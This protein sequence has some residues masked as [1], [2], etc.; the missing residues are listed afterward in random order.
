V[1]AHSE[2]FRHQEGLMKLTEAQIHA[3]S[4]HKAPHPGMVWIEGGGF[5]MGSNHHYPEEAP[6][7][8]TSVMD[9]WIDRAPV[10]N[11]EFARFVA[12]TGHVTAA[13]RATPETPV[14]ASMVFRKP[15]NPDARSNPLHWW[16]LVPGADWNHPE[17]PASSI[18]GRL[19]HPAVHIA[20]DDAL[21]YAVWAGK[22]LP[23][24]SEW[25]YAAR[26]GLDGADYSW[27]DS[28]CPEGRWMANIWRGVFPHEDRNE[29]QYGTTRV[30]A[31]PPNAYGLF[32]MIGNV[33]EWTTDWY[34]NHRRPDTPEQC[35]EA[36]ARKVMKGGSYLSAP[37]DCRRYR[38]A[39]RM[40]QSVDS[41][42]CHLGFRC[43]ARRT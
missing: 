29:R 10:T 41:G 4:R 7:H 38:P 32:D 12:A 36:I 27:G 15:G 39:A 22:S 19:D 9:F 1:K 42:A 2:I 20:F 11:F 28:F 13:E 16:A 43:V 6:A 40:A 34:K 26:G 30:G 25:E 3:H 21:A 23:S 5:R 33:W 24:E 31:F 35:L 17:G 37:N 8:Y 18:V 14:P